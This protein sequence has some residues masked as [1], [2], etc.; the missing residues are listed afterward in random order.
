M[1]LKNLMLV[2]SLRSSKKKKTVVTKYLIIANGYK[3]LVTNKIYY[4]KH[5]YNF[6]YVLYL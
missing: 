5:E 3:Y 4:K 6:I 1:Y 2:L